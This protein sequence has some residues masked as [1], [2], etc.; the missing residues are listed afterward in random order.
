[1]GFGVFYTNMDGNAVF[2]LATGLPDN[3]A[4][5]LSITSYNPRTQGYNIFGPAVV[6]PVQIQSA[7]V[8]LHERTGYTLQWNFS[9]QRQLLKNFI[10]EAGYIVTLGI[11]LEQNIQINNAQPGLGAVDPR[12]PYLSLVYAPGIVFPPDVNIQGNSVPVGFINFLANSAQSNYHS[13]F[14]RLEKRF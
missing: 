2:K 6:G 13:G 8:D 4:Q 9:V 10:L 7:N 12:R 14:V 11:K 3:Y 1:A 5:T